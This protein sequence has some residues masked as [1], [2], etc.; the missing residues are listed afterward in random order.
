MSGIDHNQ[1]R[2]DLEAARR[3]QQSVADEVGLPRAYWWI[4]A[5]AWLVL[6]T[7]GDVAPSWA[8]TA[9]T[10]LFAFGHSILA[11][12]LLSGRY[13]TNRVQVSDAAVSRRVPLVVVGIML[14]MIAVTIGLAFALDADGANHA[15][16]WASVIVAS[17]VGFGG[18][19]ILTAGR[20]LVRA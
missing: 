13:R 9:A 1:A 12:R 15:G 3:A 20:R 17:I 11:T 14:A 2:N 16:I 5:A 8:S 19:E 7:L 6:G 10:V 4:L 18:P